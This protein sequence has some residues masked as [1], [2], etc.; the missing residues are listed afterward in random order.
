MYSGLSPTERANWGRREQ[1]EAT[2]MR[3]NVMFPKDSHIGLCIACYLTAYIS[4]IQF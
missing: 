2:L 1:N 4:Y 3:S